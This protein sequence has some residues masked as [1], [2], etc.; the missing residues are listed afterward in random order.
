MKRKMFKTVLYSCTVLVFFAPLVLLTSK[1]IFPFIVP[2]V[3]FLRTAILL[4]FGW[5]VFLI[6]SKKEACLPKKTPLLYTVLFF[7][8]CLGISTFLGIDWYKSFW[9]NHERML[10]FFTL[11]HYGVFFLVLSS[12]FKTAAE[13]KILFRWFLGAGSVVMLLGFWQYFV[14][15]HFLLNGGSAR[16]SATLGNAIYYSGYGLFLFF[17][18]LMLV[19]QEKHVYWKTYAALGSVL[20][21]VGIFLGGTRGT[22]LGLAAGLVCLL[23]LYVWKN[24]VDKNMR[25]AS[26]A[27]GIVLCGTLVGCIVFKD[28]KFIR[29]I[30]GVGRLVN[31]SIDKP[32]ANNR[33]MAWGVAV[34]A[35]KERPI[36]GWGPNNFVYAFNQYYRPEFLNHGY[37]ETWFDNAHSMI[38]NTLATLGAVGLLS[39]CALFLVAFWLLYRLVQKNPERFWVYGVLGCFFVAHFVHNAF[40]FEN[41]TSY[42][43]FFFLL[44]FLQVEYVGTFLERGSDQEEGHIN[45]SSIITTVIIVGV[46]LC[47]YTT[48]TLPARANMATLKALRELGMNNRIEFAEKALRIPSP[49]I[50]DIRTD[51]A[52]IAL[53][54]LRQPIHKE[55][56]G[57]AREILN[58]T[59][60]EMEKSIVLHPKDVRL[61]ITKFQLLNMSAAVN[62]DVAYFVQAEAVLQDAITYS[63]KRQQLYFMLA[64]L[65]LKT[66]KSDKAVTLLEKV[67]EDGPT[68]R[69]S[70]WKLI[71]LYKI[72][73]KKEEMLNAVERAKIN[74]IQF[75]ED[76]VNQIQEMIK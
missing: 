76:Q 19:V 52:R 1:F 6:L 36:F 68:V 37:G 38:F 39:Y 49:H 28:S 58:F 48:N 2:K 23:V 16:V 65:Y 69:E 24:R 7:F 8:C 26:I 5:Y 51:I 22:I 41:P 74:E 62:N 21:F 17:A 44:A 43:Y 4:L 12:V 70:W 56:I 57:I 75:L 42:I 31:I 46:V 29:S 47:V 10:G 59:S 32:G 14:D 33:I 72:L 35:W 63:P 61:L 71:T 11:V 27:L 20:G 73:G 40:A 55:N 18:G 30:P 53:Q 13:W 9:D 54:K 45:H 34:E 66:N 25:I 15:T 3:I 67:V 50:D 64:E 60:S